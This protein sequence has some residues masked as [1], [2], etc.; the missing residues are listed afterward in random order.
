[1]WFGCDV[2]VIRPRREALMQMRRIVDGEA[3]VLYCRRN[4]LL[5]RGQGGVSRDK[6]KTQRE[7]EKN[8]GADT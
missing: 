5:W 8:N 4:L 2:Q 7:G 3:C 1:M 6:F